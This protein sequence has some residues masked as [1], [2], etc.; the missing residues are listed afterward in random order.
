MI[1][2]F[3]AMPYGQ[4]LNPCPCTGSMESSPLDCQGSPNNYE[5]YH[6]EWAGAVAEK[7]LG[8]KK[9]SNVFEIA[10]LDLKAEH[11]S[12][13]TVGYSPR[14]WTHKSTD[15]TGQNKIWIY[16]KF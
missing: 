2:F 13:V 9:E 4:G 12:V 16:I 14:I 1:F 15:W 3:L 11:H 7:G 6:E 8:V 5:F 10:L